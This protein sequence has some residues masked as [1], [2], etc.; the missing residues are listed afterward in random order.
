MNTNKKTVQHIVIVIV[1]ISLI[2]IAGMLASSN[3]DFVNFMMKLH[4]G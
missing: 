4:G 2:V 3:F 1:V